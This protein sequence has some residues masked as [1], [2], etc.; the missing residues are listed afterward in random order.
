MHIT[1]T[2][3]ILSA[4]QPQNIEAAQPSMNTE[5]SNPP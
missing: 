2:R 1:V 4:S 5:N 3:P